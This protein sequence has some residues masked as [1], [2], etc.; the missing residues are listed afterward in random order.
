[1]DTWTYRANMDKAL[2]GYYRKAVFV[3]FRHIMQED[4]EFTEVVQGT[5]VCEV[6]V[7][8][9]CHQTQN[10]KDSLFYLLFEHQ[11]WTS[12]RHT[13]MA[14]TNPSESIEKFLGTY[15]TLT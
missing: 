1:M 15:Q 9:G 12:I 7:T 11:K 10:A 3:Q 14:A 6:P 8:P 5:N 4:G 13:T 2:D